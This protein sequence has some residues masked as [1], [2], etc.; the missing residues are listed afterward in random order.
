[1]NRR[2][3]ARAASRYVVNVL[4]ALRVD[5]PRLHATSKLIIRRVAERGVDGERR[6]EWVAGKKLLQYP[7][8]GRNFGTMCPA[9]CTVTK[10]RRWS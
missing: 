7:H 9:P 2:F 1:M 6:R 5:D 10:E 3:D 8:S 4:G